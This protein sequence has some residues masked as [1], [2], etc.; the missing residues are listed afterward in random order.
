MGQLIPKDNHPIFATGRVNTK[1]ID[2]INGRPTS[3]YVNNPKISFYAKAF[4]NGQFCMY[5]NDEFFSLMDSALTSNND[6]RPFYFYLFNRIVEL[7]DGAVSEVAAEYCK[8]YIEKYPCEFL[9]YYN[10]KEFA[11]PLDTWTMFVGFMF[12]NAKNCNDL[13]QTI[14]KKITVGCPQLQQQW[15]K[16]KPDIRASINE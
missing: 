10:K 6:T 8:N 7:S 11:I 4:Y 2:K 12:D 5:D 16:L 1:R 9:N 13:L 15:D 3:Y 14:D